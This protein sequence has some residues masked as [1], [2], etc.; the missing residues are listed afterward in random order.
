M[1]YDAHAA[2]IPQSFPLHYLDADTQQYIGVIAFN[3]L[4]VHLNDNETLPR[5]YHTQDNFDNDMD[6]V[7]G[8]LEIGESSNSQVVESQVRDQS[9]AHLLEVVLNDETSDAVMQQR[10][11]RNA[12]EGQRRRR[13]TWL[14]SKRFNKLAIVWKSCQMMAHHG[15]HP[16]WQR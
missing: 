1:S 5:I 14:R 11:L 16:L 7:E 6:L 13:E 2:S 10:W 3:Q 8:I 4:L 12:I 15:A 9:Y